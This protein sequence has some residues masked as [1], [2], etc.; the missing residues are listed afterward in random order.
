MM[1][2]LSHESRIVGSRYAGGRPEMTVIFANHYPR[3]NRIYR[4]P[5]PIVISVDIN[6]QQAD[7]SGNSGPRKNTVYV[8]PRDKGMFCLEITGP[9]DR[10]ALDK[11]DIAG[12]TV[13]H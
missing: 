4:V 8:F 10:I 12:A 5:H 1:C 6:R 11:F 13:N 7:I 9:V 3:R 2:V